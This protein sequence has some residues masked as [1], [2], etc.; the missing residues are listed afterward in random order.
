MD[1]CIRRL[2]FQI[3]GEVV[4]LTLAS[5][6]PIDGVRGGSRLLA[7]QVKRCFRKGERVLLAIVTLVSIKLD[8]MDIAM[9]G[10]L[11]NVCPLLQEFQDVFC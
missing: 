2:L 7:T 1:W 8:S 10:A 5:E 11:L 6:T 4:E 3:G 9:E